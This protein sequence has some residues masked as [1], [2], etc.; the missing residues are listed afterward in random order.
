MKNIELICNLQSKEEG[1]VVQKVIT[2][3][4]GHLGGDKRFQG[5]PKGGR[6]RRELYKLVYRDSERGKYNW[7]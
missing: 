2:D 1:Q 4:E 3:G 5:W 7:S 6:S